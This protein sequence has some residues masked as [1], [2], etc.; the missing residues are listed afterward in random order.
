MDYC[1]YCLWKYTWC[2]VFKLSWSCEQTKSYP[3]LLS[4]P[5]IFTSSF[6]WR[7]GDESVSVTD[8]LDFSAV[9][10]SSTGSSLPALMPY[11]PPTLP[12][13]ANLGGPSPPPS[14]SSL[15]LEVPTSSG[16]RLLSDPVEPSLTSTYSSL[17]S[18]SVL[19]SSSAPASATASFVSNHFYLHI[20]AQSWNLR[21][22]DQQYWMLCMLKWSGINPATKD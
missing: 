10:V 13:T 17:S 2:T 12:L 4:F 1:K 5:F 6:F 11:S 21:L 15:P 20:R 18:T 19:A 8:L 9:S 14:T 3:L 7:P 22:T 16:S